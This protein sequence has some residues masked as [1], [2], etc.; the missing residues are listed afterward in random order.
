MAESGQ[1]FSG[2][3]IG[4]AHLKVTRCDRRGQLTNSIE[5][6]CPLWQGIDGL[7][8]SLKQAL[9]LLD[10]HQDQ[11][12]IT[13]TGESADCFANR[14]Q[15]VTDIINTITAYLTAANCHVF[16]QSQT[17]LNLADAKQHWRQVASMNWLATGSW[18]AKQYSD[19]LL[20]DI[21]ST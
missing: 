5:L 13:M 12:F 10:N 1:F 21:G 19:A 18:L 20:I 9:A 7:V 16:S 11:H 2:W 17:W 15:G 3:D 4:G 14:Q 6:A 8:Q